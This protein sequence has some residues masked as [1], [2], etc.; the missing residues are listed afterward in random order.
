MKLTLTNLTRKALSTPVGLLAPGETKNQTMDPEQ[1]YRASLELQLL[2]DA[3]YVTVTVAAEADRQDDLEPAAVGTASVA[4][5]AVTAAKLASNAVETAKINAGAVTAAK[6]ATDAVA[7]GAIAAGGI[8]AADNFA[9]GVV[10][11]AAL[12]ASAVTTAKINN[13][14]VT[15]A[16]MNMSVSGEQTGTGSSQNVAHSLTG[17]PS[18]VLAIL[19][20]VPAGQAVIT[21]GAHD[22]TNAVLTVTSGAKFKVLAII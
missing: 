5:G 22:G 6:L 15:A 21:Y 20:D 19:T 16:K 2:E 17:T 14:A 1:A 3:G 18:V 11:A 7:A 12:G 9:A 4:N 8:D 13:L 10:D